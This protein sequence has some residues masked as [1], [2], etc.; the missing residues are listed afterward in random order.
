MAEYRGLQKIAERMGWRCINTV[1]NKSRKE[2]FLAYRVKQ[3]RTHLE[4]WMTNDE[5]ITLWLQAKCNVDRQRLLNHAT[6]VQ[7]GMMSK[8]YP[9]AEL[10][11][12]APKTSQP[13]TSSATQSSPVDPGVTGCYP[14][15]DDNENK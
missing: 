8:R 9:R 3:P 1:L 7:V 10:T 2:G 5:L 14:V 4:I 12:P 13:Y 11:A 15:G 6:G